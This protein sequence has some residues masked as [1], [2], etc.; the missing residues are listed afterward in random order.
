MA[1]FNWVLKGRCYKLGHEVPHAGHVIPNRLIVA[2][3]MDPAKLVP[4]FEKYGYEL[5]GPPLSQRDA[6]ASAGAD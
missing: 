5:L 4:L 1:A 6:L 3:E 2:R